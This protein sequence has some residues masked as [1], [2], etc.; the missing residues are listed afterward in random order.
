LSKEAQRKAA[1]TAAGVIAEIERM[2]RR[3]DAYRSRQSGKKFYESLNLPNLLNSYIIR[4]GIKPAL[5]AELFGMS[6]QSLR[7]ILDGGTVSENL[8]FRIRNALEAQVRKNKAKGS[9]SAVYEGD[10][11]NAT[12][13]EVQNAIATV[14]AKLVFLKKVV[15]SS[16]FLHST[17]S[18][19]DK[20]QVAQLLSM[21]VAALEA[22]RAPLVDKKKTQGF[23]RWLGKLGKRSIEKG[24]EGK[25]TEAIGDA[26][27]AGTELIHRLSEQSGTSD[28][29]SIIT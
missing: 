17:D 11:R 6:V 8:L 14:S 29:G 13:E 20:I 1:T 28:L 19:I 26:V 10:W 23:F 15:E 4:S 22:L 27:D 7:R 18:P 24:V 9:R 12:A 3:D 16:N 2:V 5:H 21:L 25:V